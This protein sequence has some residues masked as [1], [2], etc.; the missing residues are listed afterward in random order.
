MTDDRDMIQCP[1]CEGSG[2]VILGVHYVSREMAIDGGDLNL[3]GQPQPEYGGCEMCGGAGKIQKCHRCGSVHAVEGDPKHY[4]C[5]HCQAILC[6]RQIHRSKGDGGYR[7]EVFINGSKRWC[8]PVSE[9]NW[10]IPDWIRAQKDYR[11]NNLKTEAPD[12][13][14]S[15]E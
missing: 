11:A 2:H 1:A 6:N 4:W 13:V 5:P 7:H 3:E 14:A 8:G 12:A 15:D 10:K 9:L